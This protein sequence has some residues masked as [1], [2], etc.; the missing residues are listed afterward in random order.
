MPAEAH[1]QLIQAT[2]SRLSSQ[3][4]TVKGWCVTVTA[5]L[6]GFGASATSAVVAAIAI[7]VIVAFAALDAYY[8]VLE[9][10]YRALYQ[11]AVAGQ[12]PDWA[13]DIDRP[14]LG[15]VAAA[16]RSPAIFLLY[17]TSFL[18]AAGV[19]AYLILK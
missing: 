2:I 10:S 4:T 7:Y 1:L 6:L 19:A 16:L 15:R 12:T 14:T 8:L 13:L 11:R 18:T 17:G 3:S 9:R 5:A